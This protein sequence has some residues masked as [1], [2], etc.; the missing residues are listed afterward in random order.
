MPEPVSVPLSVTPPVVALRSAVPLIVTVFPLATVTPPAPDVMVPPLKV[1]A[2]ST[3]TVPALKA[4]PE[5]VSVPPVKLAPLVTDTVPP[6]RVKLPAVT[7]SAVAPAAVTLSRPLLSVNVP[8]LP[9]KVPVER[10]DVLEISILPALSVV[11]PVTESVFVA[12]L[13]AS[14][15]SPFPTLSA[16]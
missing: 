8:P 2:L 6:D 10:V 5:I 9:K 11:R 3:V 7:E 13:R 12:V 15:A 1:R 16:A 14:V 4:P